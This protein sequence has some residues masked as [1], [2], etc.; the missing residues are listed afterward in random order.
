MGGSPVK[1][2]GKKCTRTSMNVTFIIYYSTEG[3]SILCVLF[4]LNYRLYMGFQN[5]TILFR[6]TF[7]FY[8]FTLIN[9]TRKE[10]K[11]KISYVSAQISKIR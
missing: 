2:Y 5:Q 4:V 7:K 8:V 10:V 6:T 1:G 11:L 3:R 9:N